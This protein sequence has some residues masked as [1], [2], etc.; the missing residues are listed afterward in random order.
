MIVFSKKHPQNK[1][2]TGIGHD[3]R[4]SRSFLEMQFFGEY[5]AG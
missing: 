3:A 2:L 1:P 5:A 4:I